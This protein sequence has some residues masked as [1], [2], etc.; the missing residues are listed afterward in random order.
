M[1]IGGPAAE[2]SQR[3]LVF[4]L[5]GI[6]DRLTSDIGCL[7]VFTVSSRDRAITGAS[8]AGPC[9]PGSPS[10]AQPFPAGG[11]IPRIAWT[12]RRPWQAKVKERLSI[13]SFPRWQRR[14]GRD[15]LD[16]GGVRS[17]GLT[18]RP[19]MVADERFRRC[20]KE[21]LPDWLASPGVIVGGNHFLTL[22][23]HGV[24]RSMRSWES[25]RPRWWEPGSDS[26]DHMDRQDQPMVGGF[27]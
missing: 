15:G 6:A 7:P 13:R 23:R 16:D 22:V 10:L 21:W 19:D 8:L 2:G 25:G 17:A 26:Q 5:K 14:C 27:R 24:F 20:G 3:R 4:G 1:T 18:R 9:D 12:R 11:R